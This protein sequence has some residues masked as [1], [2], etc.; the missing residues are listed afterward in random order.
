MRKSTA[1]LTKPQTILIHSVRIKRLV[2]IGVGTAAMFVAGI[3]A[4]EA[5]AQS[6]VVDWQTAAGGKMAFDVVSVKKNKA[7]VP[8]SNSNVPLGPGDYYHPTGGLFTA[9]NI[10]PF[11][12]ILFAYKVTGNQ[13]RILQEEAPKWIFSDRFDIQARADGNPAKD[14]LRLMMQSLLEDRFKLAAHNEIRQLPVFAVTQSKPGKFGPQLQPHPNSAPCSSLLDPSAASTSE[15]IAGGFPKMCGGIQPL[16]PSVAE[17]TRIGARNVTMEFMAMNL[18]SAGNL[19]R[20]VIN[21]TGLGGT[22]D[23]TLEWMPERRSTASPNEANQQPE[24]S[25]PTFLEALQEQLGLKLVSQRG[26]VEALVIL[27]S[28]RIATK[29]T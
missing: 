21:Q 16:M 9:T 15:T 7:G 26:P 25:G 6:P 23:F 29:T 18:A 22:F 28:R 14:Q 11:I 10:S 2:L 24:D 27:F 13:F 4:R 1:A 5:I 20:A 17:R 12:Y 19:D 8:P 3:P